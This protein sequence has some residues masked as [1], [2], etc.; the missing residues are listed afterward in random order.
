ME[1]L[2]NQRIKW[3]D[4]AKGILILLVILGHSF[5]NT[6]LKNILGSFYMPAFFI[7]SGFTLKYEKN[8]KFTE[9]LKKRGGGYCYLI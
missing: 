8:K 6:E 1:K 9:M 5:S 7:F 3:L 2:S 4:T